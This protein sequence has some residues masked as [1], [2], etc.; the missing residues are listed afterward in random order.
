[1]RGGVEVCTRDGAG[2]VDAS[3]GDDGAL[4]DGA[5]PAGW[6][7]PAWKHRRAIDVSAGANGAPAGYSVAITLDHAAL[8]ATGSSQASGNDV[9]IVRESG[10]LQVDRALDTGAAWNSASTKLW[11]S[12]SAALAANATVRFWVYYGNASASTP[13]QDPKA[14]FLFSEDFEGSTAAWSFDNGVGVSTLRAH[15]GT[16]AIMTPTTVNANRD[17]TLEP[18]DE[19]NIA[20][21]LWWNI[22]DLA[23]ADLQ[24]YVR[25]NATSVWLTNLQPPAAGAPSTWDIAKV[26]NG[27]Y[28]EVIPPPQGAAAPPTD[29]WFRVTMYAYNNQMAV[30]IGGT[31]YVPTTGFAD[32]G[33]TSTGDVGFG[34]YNSSAQVWYDDATVRR[35]VLPEPTVMLGAAQSLP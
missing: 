6:W 11:F 23:A 20:Y 21:E 24:Q 16:K 19:S 27:T 32:I 25:G 8:V 35:F 22:D 14:V 17:A 10:A 31:R 33:T 18:I 12:T 1:M 3:P 9:R 13:P 28:S 2:D 26:V 30:D 15:R 34:A 29:Q 5:I 7:D 4:P